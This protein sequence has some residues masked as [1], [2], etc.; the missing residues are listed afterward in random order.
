MNYFDR[1]KKF[2][3]GFRESNLIDENQLGGRYSW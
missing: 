1:K 3:F 2:T